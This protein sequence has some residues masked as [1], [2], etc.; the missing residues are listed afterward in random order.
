[1]KS[2][3]RD[4]DY[5]PYASSNFFCRII[6][7]GLNLYKGATYGSYAL[8]F[9]F[10]GFATGMG[11]TFPR[12]PLDVVNK[13]NRDFPGKKYIRGISSTPSLTAVCSRITL[14]PSHPR[15]TISTTR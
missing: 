14:F 7:G 9:Y 11:Q 3:Y 4:K 5:R 6:Y 13:L 8:A 15:Q 1:M 12:Y 2:V 10:P